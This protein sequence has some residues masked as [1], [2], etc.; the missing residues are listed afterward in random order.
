MLQGWACRVCRGRRTE[1]LWSGQEGTPWGPDYKERKNCTLFLSGT[2]TPDTHRV[3]TS[4][5]QAEGGIG[6]YSSPIPPLPCVGVCTP[7]TNQ[8][9]QGGRPEEQVIFGG[10][11]HGPRGA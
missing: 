10:P 1:G 6:P 11:C 5:N 2:P 7:C 3:P 8:H 4:A 9:T